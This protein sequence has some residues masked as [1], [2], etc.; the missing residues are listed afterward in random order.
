M[1]KRGVILKKIAFGDGRY[2][3]QTSYIEL[4]LIMEKI[5]AGEIRTRELLLC[6]LNPPSMPLIE[7]SIPLVRQTT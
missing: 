6:G 4:V 3:N 2:G 7:I 1:A 5:F